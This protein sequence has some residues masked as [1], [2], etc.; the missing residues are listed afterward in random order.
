MFKTSPFAA[1]ALASVFAV[2]SAFAGG[3]ITEGQ[4]VDSSDIVFE[5]IIP[6]VVSFA[7]VSGDRENG[8]HGTFVRIPAGQATPMHTHGAEYEAVVIQG[9]FENPIAGNEGSMV[10]LSAGS[11]YSVPADAV[12]VTRCAADSPVDCVSFFWQGVPFD[13]AM[14]E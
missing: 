12:H 2:T 5:D 11:Y 8:A 14:V 4:F 3:H 7:T 13:F 6:G 10:T 9:M 1:A